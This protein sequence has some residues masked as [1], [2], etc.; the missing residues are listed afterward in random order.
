MVTESLEVHRFTGEHAAKSFA[1]RQI[2]TE[3]LDAVLS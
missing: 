2:I 3:V 1:R